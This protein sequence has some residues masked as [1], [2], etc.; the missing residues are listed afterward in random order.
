MAVSVVLVVPVWAEE[1]RF[2]LTIDYQVLR[3]AVLT[4]LQEEAGDSIKVWRTADGCSSFL[5]RDVTVEPAEGRLKIAGPAMGG[6]GLPFL[7]LCWANMSWTGRA[8]VL[9]RPEIGPDWQ[10]R[11]RDLETS[12]YDPSGQK[13][14]LA[15]RLFAMAKGGIEA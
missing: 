3:V 2:P 10:L 12:L 9:A 5:L 11:F 7:G 13:R 8:E 15:T 4:H 6:A 1:S 14:G